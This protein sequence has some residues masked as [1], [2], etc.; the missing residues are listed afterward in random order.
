[1]IRKKKCLFNLQLF[2]MAPM[3]H[4]LSHLSEK[5]WNRQSSK[6]YAWAVSRFFIDLENNN[7]VDVQWIPSDLNSMTGDWSK[8][9]D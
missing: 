1:M 7:F 4:P 9:I 6:S 3:G 8:F 5:Y 2:P